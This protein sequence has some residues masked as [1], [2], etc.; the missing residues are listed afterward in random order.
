M[1]VYDK[2]G[3]TLVDIS[4]EAIR[5]AYIEAIAD[6]TI[7]AGSAIG[8]TLSVQ[9][10]SSAW[11]TYANQAYNL[12]L[13]AYRTKPNVCV[14]FFISTDQ[15]GSGLQQ[16]RFVNNIDKDGMNIISINLGDTVQDVYGETTIQ[17]FYDTTKQVKNYIGVVGNHEA[18]HGADRMYEL[19]FNKA[20]STTNLQRRNPSSKCDC[21]AVDDTIHHVKWLVLEDYYLNADGTGYTHGF[22]GATVDWMIDE[23]SAN[24]GLDVIILMHWP[25]WRKFAKRGMASEVN[26]GDSAMGFTN[27]WNNDTYLL[28][29]FFVAR[30]NK[31]SGTFAD[32]N[33][34]SHAYNFSQCENDLLCTL[35]GH[36]HAEWYTTSYGLTGYAA[37]R[38]YAG[39]TNA[40]K[41]V[42]GLA[43]RDLQKLRIWEF[44]AAGVTEELLLDI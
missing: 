30:K 20:F 5:Q 35:H 2:N 10:Y 42:F 1:S 28:W 19:T 16:H 24:D 32:I 8:A 39:G 26:D 12:M 44:G 25:C 37:D 33:G 3:N 7:N 11:E 18:K 15:H 17:G 31:Q 9:T 38:Y 13:D 29:D 43:D 27:R 14:P 40:C 22:D 6:G 21:Y 36:T 41:C 34:T 4:S 23:L